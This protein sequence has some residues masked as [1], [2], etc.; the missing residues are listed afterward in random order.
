MDDLRPVIGFCHFV[1]LTASRDLVH[2]AYAADLCAQQASATF[3]RHGGST[4]RLLYDRLVTVFRAPSAAVDGLLELQRAIRLLDFELAAG[5][6]DGE[7][8]MNGW[9]RAHI[10]ARTLAQAAQP[11]EVLLDEEVR[12]RLGAA[13]CCEPAG[14][15]GGLRAWRLLSGS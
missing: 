8:R 2:L 9:G 14:E 4:E 15:P 1:G 5:L 13:V 11:G 7:D 3:G 12:L 10:V 6:G